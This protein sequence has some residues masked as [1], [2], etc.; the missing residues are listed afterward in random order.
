MTAIFLYFFDYFISDINCGIG[1]LHAKRQILTYFCDVISL[2]AQ[3]LLFHLKGHTKRCLQTNI[4]NVLWLSFC[5]MTV[6]SK[7]NVP[8][9]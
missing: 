5:D 8:S 9:L 4:E 6:P 2:L 3:V 1:V 7:S